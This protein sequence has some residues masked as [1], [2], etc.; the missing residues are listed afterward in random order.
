MQNGSMGRERL[1]GWVVHIGREGIVNVDFAMIW[2]DADY[3]LLT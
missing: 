1:A 3:N 2:C